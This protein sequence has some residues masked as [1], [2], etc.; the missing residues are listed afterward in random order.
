M[1]RV[2]LMLLFVVIACVWMTAYAH[3]RGRSSAPVVGVS[4]TEK[5]YS[6]FAEAEGSG[7][8]LEFAKMVAINNVLPQLVCQ[9][10]DLPGASMHSIQSL[11]G[12]TTGE[13]V[14]KIFGKTLIQG[15]WQLEDNVY[16]YTIKFMIQNENTQENQE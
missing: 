5:S 9:T 3:E 10:M 16:H 14:D 15:Y 13:G 2:S 4:T 11:N 1:R 7:P 12:V 8:S 6:I